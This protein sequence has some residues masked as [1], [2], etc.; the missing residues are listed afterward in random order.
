MGAPAKIKRTSISN[1]V[2]TVLRVVGMPEMCSNGTYSNTV[3]RRPRHSSL[4]CPTC[5]YV[6]P[7]LL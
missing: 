6:M 7:V 4:F 3:L 1:F 5:A 2:R